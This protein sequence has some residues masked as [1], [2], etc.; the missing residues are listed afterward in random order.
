MVINV[1]GDDDAFNYDSAS[2]RAS[3]RRYNIRQEYRERE[4]MFK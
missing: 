4:T 2:N 1:F 3:L